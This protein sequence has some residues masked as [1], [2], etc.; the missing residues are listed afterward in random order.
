MKM[1]NSCT[2]FGRIVWLQLILATFLKAPNLVA[3]RH[4]AV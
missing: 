1:S 4:R 2:V 3:E